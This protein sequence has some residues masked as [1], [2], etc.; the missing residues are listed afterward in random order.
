MRPIRSRWSH[1]SARERPIL[2]D[3]ER[4]GQSGPP[5]EAAGSCSLFPSRLHRK[6]ASDPPD[7]GR[8]QARD[9]GCG[10]RSLWWSLPCAPA[11]PARSGYHTRLLRGDVQEKIGGVCGRVE[12]RRLETVEK[13][14]RLGSSKLDGIDDAALGIHGETLR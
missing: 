5:R 11:V 1:A 6:P 12:S 10:R 8:P 2:F 14:G 4:V 7:C 13:R 3:L 9:S